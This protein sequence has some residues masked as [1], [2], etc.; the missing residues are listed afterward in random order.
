MERRKFGKVVTFFF[1]CLVF[2]FLTFTKKKN[3]QRIVAKIFKLC[4]NFRATE[5]FLKTYVKSWITFLLTLSQITTFTKLRAFCPVLWTCLNHKMMWK[6]KSLQ[7]RMLCI[8]IVLFV[9]GEYIRCVND[10]TFLDLSFKHLQ[11]T[12]NKSS[13]KNSQRYEKQRILI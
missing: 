10:E 5:K 2:L 8:Y 1:S 7:Q 12:E 11:N 13:L 6:V 9:H 4:F 3:C